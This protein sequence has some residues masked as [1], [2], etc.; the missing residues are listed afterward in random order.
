M[1]SCDVHVALFQFSSAAVFQIEEDAHDDNSRSFDIDDNI[2]E[3]LF[4]NQ[5]KNLFFELAPM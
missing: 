1:R 3:H 2:S 5:T 4:A